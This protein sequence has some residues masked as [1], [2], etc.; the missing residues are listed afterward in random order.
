MKLEAPPPNATPIVLRLNCD[1]HRSTYLLLCYSVLVL[2]RYV[3]MWPWHWPLTF[4]VHSL[5]VD[6]SL[7]QIWAESNNLRLSCW[8]NCYHILSLSNFHIW[9]LDLESFDTSVVVQPQGGEKNGGIIYREKL[10]VHPQAEQESIFRIFCWAEEILRV[11]MVNSVVFSSYSLYFEGDGMASYLKRRN[12]WLR[13]PPI[14]L[15]PQLSR[16]LVYHK[17][18]HNWSQLSW[19]Y[20][21][22]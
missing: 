3:T 20:H 13:A 7:H 21:Y 12:T 19:Y 15:H 17:F 4:A 8:A 18:T 10:E 2:I 9:P 16:F 1:A 22:Q 11:G 6:Q 5:S 14:A